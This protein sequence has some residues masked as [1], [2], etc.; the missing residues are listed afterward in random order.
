MRHLI[1]FLLAFALPFLAE[2]QQ[3]RLLTI[4]EWKGHPTKFDDAKAKKYEQCSFSD[5]YKAIQRRSF[6]PF[7]K[8]VSIKLISFEAPMSPKDND[9]RNNIDTV[10]LFSPMATNKFILNYR[11]VKEISTLSDLGIDSLTNILYNFGYTPVTGNLYRV[12]EEASC[13]EPRNAILFLDSA[14]NVSQYIEFCFE[15][16]KYYYSSPKTKPIDYCEQKYD[17][18]AAFFL[19]HGV[20][21]GAEERGD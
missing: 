13:Y 2:A 7:S 9:A 10:P 21:Y 11:K 20:K 5:K 15:C 16:R 6:F 3:P 19:R 4:A 17:M 14:G 12:I 8:A 18:L 1:F